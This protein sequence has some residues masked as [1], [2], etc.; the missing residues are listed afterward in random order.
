MLAARSVTTAAV[1]LGIARTFTVSFVVTTWASGN[2][3]IGDAIT[4]KAVAASEGFG[5]RPGVAVMVARDAMGVGV[6]AALVCKALVTLRGVAVAV[7][8]EPALLS[9]VAVLP[10][11]SAHAVSNITRSNNATLGLCIPHPLFAR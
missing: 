10:G 7:S 11:T 8:N 6:L 2:P 4:G 3:A 9:G 1:V 5:V